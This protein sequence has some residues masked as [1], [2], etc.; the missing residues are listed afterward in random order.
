MSSFSTRG[1]SA[2]DSLDEPPPSVRE[3]SGTGLFL[4]ALG[5]AFRRVPA[6][7]VTWVLLL[8]MTLPLAQPWLTWFDSA[9]GSRY[10]PGSLV[11][12]MDAPFRADHATAMGVLNSASG[13]AAGLVALLAMLLGV[14]AA[15]GWLTLLADERRGRGFTRFVHGG[16]QRFF[17]FAR[18]WL[19]SLALLALWNWVFYG[20]P[21]K[22]LV[23]GGLVGVPTDDL[24]QLESLG[25]ELHAF[26]LRLTQD[27]LFAGFAL[28]T[29][30]WAI[31]TRTRL[32]ALGRWS[33]AIAG[34]RTLFVLLRHPLRTLRPLLLLFLT[35]LIVVSLVAGGLSRFIDRG[36]TDDPSLTRVAILLLI[37]QL[38]LIFREVSRGA[39]YYAALSVTRELLPPPQPGSVGGDQ[40]LPTSSPSAAAPSIGGPGG[41]QYPIGDAGGDGDDAGDSGGTQVAF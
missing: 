21:W 33:V 19:A 30:A 15:G 2:W 32:V 1:S 31:Y 16:A 22:R 24:G 6:W 8:A 40:P 34:L 5:A 23:L 39:G 28:F 41:P 3:R 26:A 13:Q 7:L 35:Q 25:S 10:A 29:L 20:M 18:V 12:G 14:F 17:C 27:G 11:A 38:A 4:T 37:S 9:I 36:L